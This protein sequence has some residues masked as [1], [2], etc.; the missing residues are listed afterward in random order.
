MGQRR[1]KIFEEEG[2]YY[3]SFAVLAWID[4]FYKKGILEMC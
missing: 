3:L 4:V 2:L 1:L